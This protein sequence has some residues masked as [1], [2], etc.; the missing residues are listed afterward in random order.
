MTIDEIAEVPPRTVAVRTHSATSKDAHKVCL[1]PSPFDLSVPRN[2][3]NLN[4]PGN[5]DAG[6][7]PNHQHTSDK[8]PTPQPGLL[9]MGKRKRGD[10]AV[11]AQ[12][13][14][15]A[16]V[17]QHQL[18]SFRG[19]LETGQKSLVGALKLARGFERQKMG[20]R[21]KD[22]SKDPKHLLRLREE[23]IVLKELDLEKVA[24]NHIAKSLC[25]AKRI[26]E[27]PA[28]Q[29]VYGADPKFEHVDSSAKGNVLG[30][31]FRCRAAM[32]AMAA[33]MDSTYSV[34]GLNQR[35]LKPS[36]NRMDASTRSAGSLENSIPDELNPMEIT[37]EEE[38]SGQTPPVPDLE[39]GFE[40]FDHR[41][42]LAGLV[43]SSEDGS[44]SEESHL[45]G[46]PSPRITVKGSSEQSL[47][48]RAPKAAETSFL[49]SLNMGGYFSG[50]DDD[51]EDTDAPLQ[52]TTQRKNRRGQRARQQLAELK[53][54][55]NAK[56]LERQAHSRDTG[57]DV[58]K[59]AVS[60]HGTMDRTSK[61]NYGE[62]RDDRPDRRTGAKTSAPSKKVSR[63]DSGPL[64]PSW[65]AAKLRKE[66]AAG[67][68]VKFE[69]KKVTFD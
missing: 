4:S 1:A 64:H 47:L 3:S 58:R 49:P 59:G 50:S 17:S 52:Q 32:K 69:G 12:I 42:G 30:R 54:G 10:E 60:T 18:A 24:K 35:T 46:R 13:Q 20:R 26:R 5:F 61:R 37:S 29:V 63:D 15:D 6:H 66:R 27:S 28:F 7:L 25:K 44:G 57:W 33:I 8:Q 11:D 48:S 56:H 14:L 53:Y 23:A 41:D 9:T 45:E 68:Q 21:Q 55:R 19:N 2:L 38:E 39:D 67:Q 34:L 31:L 22:A 43:A 16:R 51:S 40:E 62:S 36:E 65:E